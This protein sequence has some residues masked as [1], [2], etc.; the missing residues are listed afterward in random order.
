[1]DYM[2]IHEKV[3]AMLMKWIRDAG[4]SATF[5]ALIEAL[6]I[7]TVGRGDIAGLL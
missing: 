1:M 2:E 3:H 7:E 6:E 5:M 4:E